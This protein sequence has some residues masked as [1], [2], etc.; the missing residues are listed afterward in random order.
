MQSFTVLPAKSKLKYHL[1][2]VFII[3]PTKIIFISFQVRA[4]TQARYTSLAGG[5]PQ[6]KGR[7]CCRHMF[8]SCFKIPVCKT[9]CF[10]C[11]LPSCYKDIESDEEEVKDEGYHSQNRGS[12]EVP[13]SFTASQQGT[14]TGTEN[15]VEM[16][17][18]KT[19]TVVLIPPPRNINDYRKDPCSSQESN[20]SSDS[21]TQLKTSNEITYIEVESVPIAKEECQVAIKES[22]EENIPNK[23]KKGETNSNA[24]LDKSSVS[25]EQNA[26]LGTG[27]E[28]PLTTKDTCRVVLESDSTET[29]KKFINTSDTENS[30]L[31]FSKLDSSEYVEC[32]NIPGTRQYV[33]LDHLNMPEK[34][35]DVKSKERDYVNEDV[36]SSKEKLNVDLNINYANIDA[37]DKHIS[38][39]NVSGET[40]L[41]SF[42]FTSSE[43]PHDY[44]NLSALEG[45]NTNNYSNK[46]ISK[47]SSEENELFKSSEKIGD[48]KNDKSCEHE[49][50]TAEEVSEEVE[51]Q[52]IED[53]DT[54]K[55]ASEPPDLEDNTIEEQLFD[56]LLK[57][58]IA[59]ERVALKETAD[60]DSDIDNDKNDK[61]HLVHVDTNE[62]SVS[63]QSKKNK[64][65]D[66][67]SSD[68]S[69][70]DSDTPGKRVTDQTKLI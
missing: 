69:D 29:E 32:D 38:S 27:Y 59:F 33:N 34:E 54:H 56:G 3:F 12:S 67:K 39:Q 44:M 19:E 47:F 7:E 4:S 40:K 22:L 15:A 61:V 18:I 50:G 10:R 57:N 8:A 21:R 49:S 1:G 37:L 23:Y 14:S 41:G 70:S 28:E 55:P 24:V 45:T 20:S 35:T 42:D 53:T 46:D 64:S 16:T 68:T 62:T 17:E 26:E 13:G 30:E 58:D 43:E 48:S 66:T 60:S 2:S 25:E 36:F 52:T 51:S 11:I 65:K 6:S 63:K 31:E 9:I 5:P